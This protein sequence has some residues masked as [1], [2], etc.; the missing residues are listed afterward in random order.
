MLFL[1]AIIFASF[2]GVI[3]Q[4]TYSVLFLIGMIPTLCLIFVLSQRY[5]A[6]LQEKRKANGFDIRKIKVPRT[7]EG[8]ICEMVTGLLLVG[9]LIAGFINH[10]FTEG[11]EDSIVFMAVFA[12]AAIV[13]L[14]SAYYPRYNTR[15]SIT[16]SRQVHIVARFSRVMAIELGLMTFLTALF[17]KHES[18]QFTFIAIV[19]GLLLITSIVFLVRFYSAD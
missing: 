15:K 1:V 17:H 16:N 9:A 14:V 12:V 7:T 4:T 8:T 13:T 6:Q 3:S 19:V 5:Q 2:K 11:N 10:V 18:L